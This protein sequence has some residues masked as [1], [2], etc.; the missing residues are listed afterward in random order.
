VI[1]PLLSL[2]AR[3][4]FTDPTNGF[5]GMSRR[6]LTDPRLRPFRAAFK[7]FSLQFYLNKWPARLGYRVVEVPVTRRYPPS[8]PVPTKIRGFGAHTALVK[9]LLAVVLGAYDHAE[10]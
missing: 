2:A 10:R 1:A 9:E 6:F 4:R 3:F 7:R 8:G 5:K